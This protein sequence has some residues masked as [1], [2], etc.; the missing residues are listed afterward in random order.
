MR[1]SLWRGEGLV[2]SGWCGDKTYYTKTRKTGE[3]VWRRVAKEGG[4]LSD[5]KELRATMQEWLKREQPLVHT[6][7]K[8]LV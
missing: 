3:K 7:N 6:Y 5:D 1:S 2:L 4:R 8:S